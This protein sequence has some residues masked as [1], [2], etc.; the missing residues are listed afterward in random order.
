MVSVQVIL[1]DWHWEEDWKRNH[2]EDGKTD[3][4]K[5]G[6]IDREI[7]LCE[8]GTNESD[9]EGEG[10]ECCEHDC[11]TGECARRDK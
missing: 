8:H 5:A 4:D 1:A 3:L 7:G 10:K 9:K 11:S 2:L 6:C